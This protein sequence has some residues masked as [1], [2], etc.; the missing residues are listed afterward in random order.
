MQQNNLLRSLSLKSDICGKWI[1][2]W[3]KK[4]NKIFL[5]FFG[6]VHYRGKVRVVIKVK[7]HYHLWRINVLHGSLLLRLQHILCAEF[8]CW[9]E[10]KTKMENVNSQAS[11]SSMNFMPRWP[12]NLDFISTAQYFVQM[13]ALEKRP[14]GSWRMDGGPWR[15]I[16]IHRKFHGYLKISFWGPF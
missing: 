4:V 16:N 8:E 14:L 9:P 3:R 7:R 13:V 15:T 2:V 10:G 11:M 1:T 5:K 12:L 6:K